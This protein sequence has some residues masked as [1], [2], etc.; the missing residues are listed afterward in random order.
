MQEILLTNRVNRSAKFNIYLTPEILDGTVEVEIKVKI[1]SDSKEPIKGK[2]NTFGFR[3]DVIPASLDILIVDGVY[4]TTLMG[5]AGFEKFVTATVELVVGDKHLFK[6][7]TNQKEGEKLVFNY[8]SG[9]IQYMTVN[10]TGSYYFQMQSAGG[11]GAGYYGDNKGGNGGNGGRLTG[12]MDLVAGVTY[13]VSAGE[14]GEYGRTRIVNG[15]EVATDAKSGGN[16]FIKIADT[17]EYVQFH[18]YGYGY[19]FDANIE[20]GQGG[21]KG[22]EEGP[23]LNGKDALNGQGSKGGAGGRKGGTN[24][25]RGDYG[26]NGRFE[27]QYQ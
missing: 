21:F 24:N 5:S 11:G 12:V 7:I 27:L 6:T 20:G 26:F 14:G 18:P 15:E 23:G 17:N 13:A 8:Y 2:L 25:G 10:K 22:T 4:E 9:P 1:T 16:C 19:T 3:M